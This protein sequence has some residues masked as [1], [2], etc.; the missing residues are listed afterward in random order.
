MVSWQSVAGVR[1]FLERSA[2]LG[3]S[4]PFLPLATNLIGQPGT[5]SFTDTNAAP[6]TPAFHRVGVPTP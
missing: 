6:A 2:N 3:A 1:Y 5:T 4:P